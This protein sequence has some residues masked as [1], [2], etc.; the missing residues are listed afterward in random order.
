MGARKS[1]KAVYV[2]RG[3]TPTGGFVILPNAL[4]QNRRLSPFARGVLADLLSRPPDRRLPS[5]DEYA[6]ENGQTRN[7]TRRAYAELAKAGYLERRPRR[8]TRRVTA[9]PT[10]TCTPTRLSTRRPTPTCRSLV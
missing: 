4:V 10:S 7:A 5:A 1:D 9:R 3:S 2:I 6:V 8:G